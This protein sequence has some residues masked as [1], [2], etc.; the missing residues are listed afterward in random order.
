MIFTFLT[1]FF[2][3]PF[4]ISDLPLAWPVFHNIACIGV[5]PIFQNE[6]TWPSKGLLI[7]D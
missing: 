6:K 2:Y 4:L 3:C 5:G 7:Y 1:S